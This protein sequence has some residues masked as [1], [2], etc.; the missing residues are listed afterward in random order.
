MK[1]FWHSLLKPYQGWTFV[2][3]FKAKMLRN[4]LAI[5]I[6]ATVIFGTL[7]LLSGNGGIQPIILFGSTLIFSSLMWALRA[8][9]FSLAE[10]GTAAYLTL[11]LAG[12]SATAF[13][14]GPY[15]GFAFG[16]MML[17]AVACI[18]L[19][20]TQFWLP[21][22]SAIFG[23]GI[24]ISMIIIRLMPAYPADFQTAFINLTIIQPLLYSLLAIILLIAARAYQEIQSQIEKTSAE[25]EAKAQRLNLVAQEARASLESAGKLENQVDTVQ[26]TSE[27]IRDTLQAVRQDMAGL[28]QTAA[29]NQRVGQ[30]IAQAS[31]QVKQAVGTQNQAVQRASTAISGMTQFIQT[32]TA[33][34][35]DKKT[36]IQSLVDN[37][38]AGSRAMADLNR[39]LDRVKV[40]S[41]Q[42]IEVMNIIDGISAQT[43][44][45]AMNAAIEAAHAGEQG[46]GFSVVAAEVRKLA[47]ETEKQSK[48]IHQNLSEIETAVAGSVSLGKEADSA[49]GTL[50]QSVD[51]VQ[52]TVAEIL[53]G[54]INMGREAGEMSTAVNAM[55][56][57]SGQVNQAV[58]TVDAQ[59]TETAHLVSEVKAGSAKV[60][61]ASTTIDQA[62]A[63]IEASVSSVKNTSLESQQSA[64]RL[65][66]DLLDLK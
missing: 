66:K 36:V 12:N 30:A 23:L 62:F 37:T 32:I 43:N 5:I 7:N 20:S 59:V 29:E 4:I 21:I 39:A 63:A 49:F 57:A 41:N 55:V 53:E 16:M 14:Y 31:Q 8:G 28:D 52:K 50:R 11:M 18:L 13:V 1:E 22:A 9:R 25:V 58:I 45:L 2:R 19:F 46:R 54:T 42:V 34:V 65:A 33:E 35:E 3:Q 60:L 48:I 44:I 51:Q 15:S 10:V 64:Q 26:V 6:P 24:V 47:V 61:Q 27:L 56:E 38:G 40:L 17:L